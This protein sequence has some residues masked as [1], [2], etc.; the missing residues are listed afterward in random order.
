[1]LLQNNLLKTFC[2]QKQANGE[3]FSS[4]GADIGLKFD[5]QDIGVFITI[6][7]HRHHKE[8]TWCLQKK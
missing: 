6:S 2:H 1:V 3:L 8:T 7:I 4:Q 5:F